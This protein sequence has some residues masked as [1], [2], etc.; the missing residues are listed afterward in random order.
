MIT[1]CTKLLPILRII[2]I[3]NPLPL[4]GV[5][6]S[7][8]GNFTSNLTAVRLLRWGLPISQKEVGKR[9]NPKS[10]EIVDVTN[11]GSVNI[12]VRFVR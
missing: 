10:D 2:F 9:K 1:K 8:T 6:N 12:Q 5:K 4:N 3:A 7:G 11:I